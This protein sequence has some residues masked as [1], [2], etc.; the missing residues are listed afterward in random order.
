MS[1]P[2]LGPHANAVFSYPYVFKKVKKIS[3]TFE[4]ANKWSVYIR[5]NY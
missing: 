2:S 4:F 1:L 3:A 5:A